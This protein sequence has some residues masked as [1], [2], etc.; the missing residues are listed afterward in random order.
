M[1]GHDSSWDRAASYEKQERPMRTVSKILLKGAVDV[2]FFRAPDAYLVVAAEDGDAIPNIKTHFDGDKLIIEQEGI[3]ISRSGGD[4]H[5]SGS[6][7]VVIGGSGGSIRVSGFGNIVAGR[8]INIGGRKSGVSM[9]FHGSV[10]SIV[11]GQGRTIV[12]I[13]LPEA[14]AIRINGSGNF[15]LYGLQQNMLSL[16][17]KGSGDITVSGKVDHLNAHVI[18]SGGVDAESLAAMSGELTVTGSGDIRAH[19]FRSVKARVTGSG[20]IVVRGNPS[21]RDHSV[22]GSGDIKFK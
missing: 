17:V 18:G 12:A 13:A 19:V 10:G 14:P 7:N 16:G 15:N 3:S 11:A 21:D 20:D 9:Q 22:T 2:V 4:I 5:V 1:H 8:S 6:G